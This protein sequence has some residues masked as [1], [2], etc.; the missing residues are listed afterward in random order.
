MVRLR[1]H[2]NRQKEYNP[3]IVAKGKKY[4][5][6]Q[7]KIKEKFIEFMEV[8]EP[9]YKNKIFLQ[10]FITDPKSENFGSTAT[11]EVEDKDK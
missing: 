6:R 8:W 1:K 4:L 9:G 2:L 3:A 5:S 11:Y 10:Y 7:L